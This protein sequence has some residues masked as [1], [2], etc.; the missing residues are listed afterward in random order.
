MEGAGGWQCFE[1]GEEFME[2]PLAIGLGADG[3]DVVTSV[4]GALRRTKVW[5][6]EAVKGMPCRA[7]AMRGAKGSRICSY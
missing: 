4:G 2:E 6:S 1:L 3:E 7:M 5:P